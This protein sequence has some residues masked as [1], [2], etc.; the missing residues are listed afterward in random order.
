MASG[1]SMIAEGHKTVAEGW[2]MFK[3]A[4]DESMPRDLP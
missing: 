3:E 1:Y 2:R 4:V